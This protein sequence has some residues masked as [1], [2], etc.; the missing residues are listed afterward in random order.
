MTGEFEAIERLRRLLPSPP[1]GETWIGDDAAVVVAPLGGLLLASDLVVAGVH[2]D[3]SF[4][5]LDDF[6]WKA[7]SVNV[8]DIAAMGGDPTHALVSVAGPPDIDLELLYEGIAE[9]V[10]A[11]GCPVVGGDLSSGAQLVV[12]VAVLGDA[13]SRPPVL[14]SGALPGDTIFVT[15][16]L[17]SSAAGLEA[18][19]EGRGHL[20]PALAAAHRRP[21]AR[22]AEGR[23][24]RAAGATAMVDV[25]DGLAADLRHLA[26]A[27]GV[28]LALDHV[29]VAEG[30]SLA[31]ALGGGEDYELAFTATNAGHICASFAEAG[32]RQPIAIGRCTADP[33]E[34]TL[35]DGE[36]P[37]AGWQHQWA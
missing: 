2:A 17:G 27:S 37:S 15:G 19:R 6:G 34:R 31:Q 29:P 14:R 28:G 30:A 10:D 5:G 16:P 13:G 25:S 12:S 36:L 24:A 3:L 33:A 21:I 1:A 26:D 8:S 18:L 22:V 4:V 7:M 32:L 35:G 11:Y 20:V 23:A 9:A